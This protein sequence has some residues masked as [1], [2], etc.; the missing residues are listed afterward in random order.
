MTILKIILLGCVAALAI[1]AADDSEVAYPQG[2]REWTHVTSSYVGEGSPSFPKY[3]GIHHIYANQPAMTG[4]RTGAFPLGSVIAFDLHAP[5]TGPGSIQPGTR[6]L[7]DVMEKRRDG[8]RFIEF[9]GDSRTEVAVTG[10]QGV[11]RCMACHAKA[12]RDGVFS[13]LDG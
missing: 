5:K 11:T 8:W 4:Y 7:V 10:A 2:F 13:R 1:G 6:T 12:R 3:A 9:I